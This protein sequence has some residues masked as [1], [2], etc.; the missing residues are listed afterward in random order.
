MTIHETHSGPAASNL[1]RYPWYVL[2]I[3]LCVYSVNWMDRYVVIILLEPIKR[4]LQLSDAALGLL[5]GFAFAMVYSLAG[6]PI[7]RWA[8]HGTR[9]SIVSLG[10]LLWSV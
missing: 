10:L 4:E 2:T 9:R 6:I 1:G 5:S 7:A 8:D 3:L